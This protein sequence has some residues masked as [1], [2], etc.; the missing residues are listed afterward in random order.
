MRI[1]KKKIQR[2]LELAGLS[3]RSKESSQTSEILSSPQKSPPQETIFLKETSPIKLR[4]KRASAAN[5]IM[6][7]YCRALMNFGLSELSRA[8]LMTEEAE[9]DISYE[10]FIHILSSKRKGTNCIKGL[11][12]LLLRDRRDSREKRAF[13]VMFQRSCETFLKYFC[14]NWIFHSQLSDRLKHLTYRGKIL[15]RIQNPEYFTNLF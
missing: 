14:V 10:R 3:S 2:S 13:K 9:N 7:N 8:Y 11:R 5:N 15:R 12:S 1:L 6:K 4:K